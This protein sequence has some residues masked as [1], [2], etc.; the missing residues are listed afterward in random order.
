M[1]LD[2]S[3]STVATEHWVRV[4]GEIDLSNVDAVKAAV[5]GSLER[6]EP[7]VLD[8]RGIQ[9]IDSVGLAAIVALRHLARERRTTL[10]LF[11]PQLAT[12][13]LLDLTGISRLFDAA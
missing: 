13:Q 7:V 2:I 6:G 5:S 4:T 8:C 9:F 11:E 3:Q 10:R 1:E 12:Q